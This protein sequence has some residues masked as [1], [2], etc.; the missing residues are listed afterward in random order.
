[1]FKRTVAIVV[2]MLTFMI[3]HLLKNK[4]N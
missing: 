4:L 3:Q 1:V 2:F